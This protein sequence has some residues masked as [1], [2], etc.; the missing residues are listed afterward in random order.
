MTG[1]LRDALAALSSHGERGQ[2]SVFMAGL[3]G[4]VQRQL[5]E[6]REKFSLPDAAGSGKAQW[7]QWADA[8]D[9]QSAVPDSTR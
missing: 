2:Q 9:A 1:R 6:L 7:Q 8:Q 4:Q 3:V 5:N